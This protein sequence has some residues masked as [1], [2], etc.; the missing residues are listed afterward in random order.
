[1]TDTQGRKLNY[2]LKSN[3]NNSD[4]VNP[5]ILTSSPFIDRKINSKSNFKNFSNLNENDKKSLVK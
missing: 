3:K 1:M 4:K 5:N 2:H